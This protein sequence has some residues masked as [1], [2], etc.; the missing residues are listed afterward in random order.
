MFFSMWIYQKTI[1]FDIFHFSKWLH[2]VE[3]TEKCDRDSIKICELKVT[4][5]FFV[6]QALMD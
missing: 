1:K 4:V 5:K 3:R 2:H 6:I